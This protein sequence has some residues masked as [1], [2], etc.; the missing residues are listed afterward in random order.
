ML[1]EAWVKAGIPLGLK[2]YSHIG[3]ESIGDV[4]ALTE[5][6]VATQGVS[7]LIMMS[8]VYFKPTVPGVVAMLKKIASVAPNHPLWYYHVP[9]M[10]GVLAGEVHEILEAAQDIPNLM[11]AKFTDY[12]LMDFLKVSHNSSR[13]NMIYGRDEQ[14]MA[15]VAFGADAMAG[16]TF[17]FLRY[18]QLTAQEAFAGNHAQAFANQL[19]V[20][21][22]CL[23]FANY[24]GKNVQKAIMRMVGM[25][26]GPPRLPKFDLDESEYVDLFNK[27]SSMNVLY[28]SHIIM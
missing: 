12:N 14:L 22:V 11:G 7:G 1:T 17:N 8:P 9:A 23:L 5:H 2:I 13:W 10:T 19:K 25:D 18:T 28:P 21:E 3:A 15:A 24:P 6:A 26:V 27:L 4:V 16:S 20:A